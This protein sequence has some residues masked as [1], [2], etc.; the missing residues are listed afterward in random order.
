MIKR[1]GIVI[2]FRSNKVIKTLKK[3]E[4]N[5]TYINTLGKYLTGYVDNDKFDEI[6]ENLS[7]LKLVKKVESSLIEME[8][9]NFSA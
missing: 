8:E 6:K 1:K 9:L 5:I 2:Y 3:F 4:I 7:K